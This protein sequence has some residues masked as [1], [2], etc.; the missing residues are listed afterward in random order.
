MSNTNTTPL[1]ECLRN[2]FATHG[3][4][5]FIV[6]DNGSSFLCN[7]FKTFVQK[8]GIKQYFYN[9]LS[10]FP[11]SNGMTERSVQIFKSAIKKIIDGKNLIGLNTITSR[12]LL[13]YGATPQSTTGKSPVSHR[14]G[15][16]M[17]HL[18]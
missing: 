6:T 8:N 18:T 16:Y 14:K 2:S 13:R 15:P 3:L 5:F 4:P 9:T 10:R 11:C 17:D 1:A 12:Y 7:E